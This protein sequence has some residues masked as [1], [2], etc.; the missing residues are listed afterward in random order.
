M[1][2]TPITARGPLFQPAHY[3]PWL[4]FI[5]STD[6]ADGGAGGGDNGKQGDEDKQSKT[7][8]QAEL[9]QIVRDRVGREK[10]KYADYDDLKSKAEGAKSVEDKLSDLEGKYAA[11]E[12]RALR[13]DIAAK[14]GIS[15][16]DRDLFLTGTDEETLTN[17]AKRLAE[18][19]ADRKKQGPHAPREGRHTIPKVD[20]ERAAVRT[21][22]GSG[23]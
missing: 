18:R 8:T 5:D 22:F 23:D 6:P 2:T 13:S 21:L 17:Q 15:A 19:E 11:A 3:R 12:A 10:A 1:N 7:F 14:H 4:R 20:D 9:D 16:E